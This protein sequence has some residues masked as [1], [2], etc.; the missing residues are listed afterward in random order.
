MEEL[1]VWAMTN[2]GNMK[3]TMFFD[4]SVDWSKIGPGHLIVFRAI[5]DPG[6]VF[7]KYAHKE[8]KDNTP[9][10]FVLQKMADVLFA[11]DATFLRYV[12][13]NYNAFYGPTTD[14]MRWAKMAR[15]S[16]TLS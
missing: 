16:G 5:A 7:T 15:E 8:I 3:E 14:L 4:P 9:Q 1:N 6:K 12:A 2:A 10:D 13:Q 11:D